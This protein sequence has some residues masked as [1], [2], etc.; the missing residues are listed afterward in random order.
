MTNILSLTEITSAQ[1]GISGQIIVNLK[2][3]VFELSHNI[4][5]RNYWNYQ[6][7]N[8][9]AEYIKTR[10]KEYGYDIELQSY[11][12]D[13]KEFS[14]IIAIKKGGN[15]PEQIIIVGAH[16]DTVMGSPGADDNASGVAGLLELARLFSKIEINKT[17]KFIAFVNEEPPFFQSK[18]MGSRVYAKIAKKNKDKISA[19]ICLE[20]IGCYNKEPKSQSY[21]LFLG[22]FYPDK[23]NFI[24]FVSNFHSISLLNRFK[25]AFKKNSIFPLETLVAPNLV[26]GVDW[27]DHSSFWKY[28]Y[29]AIMVTDTAFYRYPYYHSELD[30]YEKL[31]YKS[32]TEVVG[33]LYYVLLELTR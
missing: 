31:D 29:K 32:M 20:M 24:A 3:H 28:G 14:N 9:A 11:V 25:N 23:A 12:L 18:D 1:V 19:M 16:Y 26:S 8:K 22:L 15:S 27:S 5:E 13:N 6:N 4:G 2:K 33:G 10:F 17:I 7:L 30:T 21:P